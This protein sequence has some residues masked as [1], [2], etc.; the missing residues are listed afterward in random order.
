MSKR[1]KYHKGNLIEYEIFKLVDFYDSILREPTITWNHKDHEPKECESLAY[2]LAETLKHYG[3]I[4]L[5]ANQVG[6]KHRVCV[7]NMGNEIWTLFNPE[8]IDHGLTPATYQEG[9]L[10]YPG[11]YLKVPRHNH[12]KVKFQAM[13]GQ[14][15]VQEFDGLTAVCVQHEID[16][17]DGI[18]YTDK[19]SPIKLDQAKRKVKKNVKRMR[20][21]VQQQENEQAPINLPENQPMITVDKKNLPEKFVYSVN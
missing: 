5:S 20:A 10:S 21:F 7:I 17:L 13:Y 1:I 6:L 15:I 12:I 19:V 11:L 4:G 16:H 18:V 9:C 2:S 3:G 8:I 14:E